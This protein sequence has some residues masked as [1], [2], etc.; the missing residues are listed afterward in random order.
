M[1]IAYLRNHIQWA[2]KYLELIRTFSK[3]K[4]CKTNIWLPAFPHTS[5]HQVYWKYNRKKTHSLVY[6]S[7]QQRCLGMKQARGWEQPK[8]SGEERWKVGGLTFPVPR[9]RRDTAA[10]TQVPA[11]VTKER[12]RSGSQRPHP[13][14]S[15]TRAKSIERE[16]NCL[17][18]RQCWRR[19]VSICKT[20]ELAHSTHKT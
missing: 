19:W 4:I 5:R 8:Q 13:R 2:K 11:W 18:H 12:N 7:Q 16:M 1:M 20:V 9:W 17:F 14:S 3:E 15:A 10:R 6:L